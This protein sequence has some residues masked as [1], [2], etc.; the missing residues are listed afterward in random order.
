MRPDEFKV[1]RLVIAIAAFLY[2]FIT[3]PFQVPDETQH[4]LKAYQ[5]SLGRLLCIPGDG[6]MGD[7]LPASIDALMSVDFPLE[8]AGQHRLYRLDDIA[9][10]WRRP[11]DPGNTAFTAFPNIASYAPTLYAPQ[12]LGIFLGRAMGLPPLG[13][14]YAARLVNALAGIGLILAAIAVIPFGKPVFWALA[15]FPTVLYQTASASPDSTIIGLGFLAT[16]LSLR[17][18]A[19]LFPVTILLG[20]AKGIYLPL[21]LA[22]QGWPLRLNDRRL[23]LMAGSGIAAAL[24]FAGWMIYSGGTQMPFHIVSRKTLLDEPTA[25]LGAQLHIILS[26]P[27]FYLRVLA[28]SFTERAPVYALQIVGRFGWN[29]ILMP[30]TVYGLAGCV[31][32]LSL[33]MPGVSP[34]RGERIR[35]LAIVAGGAVLIETALYLSGTPLGADYIQGTQGRYFIPFL[36]LAGLALLRP[37]RRFPPVIWHRRFTLLVIILITVG[38]AVDLD[39]FWI[40]G[41]TLYPGI[42]PISW[43]LGGI[44]RVFM[45]P[46]GSW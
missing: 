35:W 17:G 2:V 21:I 14:F 7:I 13:Q 45:L 43:T 34:L 5:L 10:G 4:F 24:I 36:P 12:A 41:F 18:G 30:L 16:A 33:L 44:L 20:L 23:W 25:D 46:S 37:Q 28:G 26:R 1:L 39:S 3:P 31:F 29:A 15:A 22:G 27:F 40:D 19:A 9:A 6:T 42:P 11:L 32:V 8:T 38:I